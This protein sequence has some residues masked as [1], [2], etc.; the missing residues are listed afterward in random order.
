MTGRSASSGTWTHQLDAVDL[1]QHQVEQH[2]PRPLGADD[3]RQVPRRA[4]HE[5]GVAGLGERV[6]DEAQRPRVVVHDQ[7]A[8]R[9]AGFRGRRR[10]R[11]RERPPR[12]P[13]SPATG[14]VKVNVAPRPAPGLSARMRP[15]CASTSPFE[16]ASPRPWPAVA[17]CPCAG[18][19]AEQVRQ[20]P[21]APPRSPR[22]R[23]RRRRARPRA[24]P[25]PGSG[26]TRE[27]ASRRSRRG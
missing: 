2:Q 12:A 27:R 6:A 9:R 19:L 14:S 24:R 13:A 4:G 5:R 10:G 18:V 7:D 26:S 22:R 21:R 15:P 11:R 3:A 8:R 23:P 20:T 17:P 16:M 25:P 1:G